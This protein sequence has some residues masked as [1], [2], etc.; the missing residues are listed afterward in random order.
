[1]L[2]GIA[3]QSRRESVVDREVVFGLAAEQY[4]GA[5]RTAAWYGWA[6]FKSPTDS[7]RRR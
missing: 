3:A 6:T 7:C 2:G 5:E 1:M 4:S